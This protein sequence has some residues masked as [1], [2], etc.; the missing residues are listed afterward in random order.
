MSFERQNVVS[1]QECC[2]EASEA[3]TSKNSPQRSQNNLS[4][5]VQLEFT[6]SQIGL[7]KLAE[8]LSYRHSRHIA[9]LVL[10]SSLS[11]KVWKTCKSESTLFNIQ[12]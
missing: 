10:H 3:H 12:K 6:F 2:T 5:L 9:Q 4:N 8:W 7:L 11:T 1:K